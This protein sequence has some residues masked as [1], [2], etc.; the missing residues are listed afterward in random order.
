MMGLVVAVVAALAY[1]FS[2]I[3]HDYFVVTMN[4]IGLRIKREMKE[5]AISAIMVII[6]GGVATGIGKPGRLAT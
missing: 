1:G 6:C 3:I 2:L 5:K 4:K